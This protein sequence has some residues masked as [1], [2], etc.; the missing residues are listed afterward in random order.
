M[1]TTTK[2]IG[3]R[4]LAE[5]IG[6]HVKTVHRMTQRGDLPQPLK[7]SRNVRLWPRSEL[8]RTLNVE[9]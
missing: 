2:F 7:L 5:A 4:E 6:V 1:T 3:P 8:S 9:L